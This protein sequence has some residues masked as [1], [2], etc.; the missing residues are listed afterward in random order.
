MFICCLGGKLLLLII[1]IFDRKIID[2]I[3]EKNGF[4]TSGE[5]LGLRNKNYYKVRTEFTPEK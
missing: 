5:F 2:R 1:H 3:P 4:V